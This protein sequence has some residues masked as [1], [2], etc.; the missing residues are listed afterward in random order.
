MPPG[1]IPTRRLT[2]KR[3]DAFLLCNEWGDLVP[4]G[5]NSHGLYVRDTRVLSQLELSIDDVTRDA[6]RARVLDDGAGL[7]V[8]YHCTA[9]NASFSVRRRRFLHTEHC[10]ERILLCN[11]SSRTIQPRLTLRYAADF[12]DIFEVRGQKRARRGTLTTRLDNDNAVAMH[13]RA[14]DGQAQES[15]LRM[16]PA[17]SH[18][19]ESTANFS[20][21]IA[22]GARWTLFLYITDAPAQLS[23]HE[24]F[25]RHLHTAARQRCSVLKHRVKIISD[26]PRFDAVF[27]QSWSDLRMLTTR[28]PQG[29]Y[30]YAGTPWFSTVFGRDGLV[31]ALLTLWMAPSLARGVLDTL[32]YYQAT[33]EDPEHDAEPGKIVHEMRQGEMARLGEVPFGRYYGSIDSTPLFLLLLGA[34]HERTG[35]LPTLRRL[36]PN[37]EA[38]LAW[39]DHYGDIDGDGFVEYASHA[40]GGLNNQ[41][42]KD[43]GDAIFYSNGD[44]ARGPVALCEVQGY[45]Y[46]A[47]RAA[48][49]L[50][51]VLD[52]PERAA[53][54]TAQA[55]ALC[56][57]FQAAF[58][59]E[60]LGTWALALDGDKKPCDVVSSNA[61]QVLLSGIASKAYAKRAVE[62]LWS[63][64]SY[65][66]W[67]VRTVAQSAARYSAN[68]YH[69]GSVWPHDNALIGLGLARY[70]FTNRAAQLLGDMFAAAIS[71]EEHR[72]P[73]L[74]CGNPR[75]S[76]QAPLPYPV[77]CRP[78]AW[79]TAA[80]PSLLQTC[81]GLS[82]HA[83]QRELRFTHPQLPAG[84]N[85]LTLQRLPLGDAHADVRLQRNGDAITVKTLAQHGEIS[86]NV[87]Q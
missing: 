30:P 9:G 3:N 48:A 79:A 18:L 68:S 1:P 28:T 24:A 39:I 85:T 34:Y 65:S 53:A 51:A 25:S 7:L 32:A 10:Y 38:A 41:G 84:I 40:Q 5:D 74:F 87:V 15:C 46:G 23:P 45:V 31:T 75:Q 63:P 50:A 57:H 86:V 81:L 61:G 54:L 82:W 16:E 37:A 12:A 67:G 70:H 6:T 29:L 22:P 43:S 49:R 64:D 17:P 66:G 11:T 20:P 77:A 14:V 69:N 71:D 59:R 80:L 4:G 62:T 52:L 44:L 42:W 78:Q 56:E 35:D 21:E 26:N 19:S 47:R 36:W 83:G 58:W 13:Y 33:E 27:R 76:N 60:E 73:E 8:R 55:D 72:L 2:L